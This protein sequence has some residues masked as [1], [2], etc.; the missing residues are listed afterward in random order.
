[1]NPFHFG[2]RERP[3]FGTYHPPTRRPIR[4]EGVVVCN[5]LGLE[6]MR[7]HRALHRLARNLAD[8]GHHVLRFDYYGTGDS[9]GDG[10]EA[11]LS[12]WSE[13]ADYAVEELRAI[14]GVMRVTLVGVRLGAAVAL[15]LAATRTDIADTALWDPVV[16]GKRYL[17]ELVR[18]SRSDRA[19]AAAAPSEAYGYA[20]P[21]RLQDQLDQ[22][23]LTSGDEPAVGRVGLF[24]S[25][26]D[27]QTE[28]LAQ[29]LAGIGIPVEHR[30]FPDTGVWTDRKRMGNAVLAPD[31]VTEV[32]A[33]LS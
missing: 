24:L 27:P 28:A 15:G 22:L 6:Y 19:G 5:P 26:P 25:D 11:D 18:G 4:A 31:L 7:T 9:S 3:L 29:R 13:D 2:P 33:W 20:L 23:D 17:G 16:L 30:A 12:V 32:C 10:G 8:Q 1:M 14:A 21:E